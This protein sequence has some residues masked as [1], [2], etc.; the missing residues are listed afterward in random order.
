MSNLKKIISVGTLKGGVGK[1][2]LIFNMAGMLSE[3]GNKVLLIDLDP[4]SNTTANCNVSLEKGDFTSSNLF[5]EQALMYLIIKKNVIPGLDIDLIPASIALTSTE[6]IISGTAARERILINYFEDNAATLEQYDYILI[7]TNPSMSIVNQN[8]FVSADD[9]ILVSTTA[10]NS[11][12]GAEMFIK[13]W[14][15]IC[16]R[17][18]MNMNIS[19][20]IM[21]QVEKN[22]KLAKDFIDNFIYTDESIVKDIALKAYIPKNISLN[23]SNE[24]ENMPI[25]LFDKKAKSYEGYLAVMSELKDK[26]VL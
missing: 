22:T 21:N 20:F 23:D 24:M 7:D 8:A 2:S 3:Q 14:S 18:R 16:K 4:Q 12:S 19:A 25:N 11:Y 15:D 9:I 26:G 1:T 17:M 13:L 5:V 10:I 6:M